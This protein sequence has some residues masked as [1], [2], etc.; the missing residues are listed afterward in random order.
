[1]IEEKVFHLQTENTSYIFRVSHLGKLENVYYGKSIK[2]VKD[3]RP[4]FENLAN[5]YPNSIIYNTKDENITLD[6]LSLEYSSIGKGDLRESACEI[7]SDI[8]GFVADFVYQ[9]Y[10]SYTG[11]KPLAGLPSSYDEY[12]ACESLEID[13]YDPVLEVTLTL[14][15]HAFYKSNI[16]TRYVELKNGEKTNLVIKRLMSMQFDFGAA[17][18]TMVTF[19]GSWAREM[20]RHDK[21]L[22]QGI[23]VND[24]K[25]GTSSNRHNPFVI[26]K[27]D[28]CTEDTGKCYGVNLVYSGNHSE[29]VEVNQYEKIR[30]LSGINP[31]CFAF[32]LKKGESFVTP[33]AVLSFSNNGLN[34]LSQNMHL[35][36]NEHIVPKAFKYKPRPVLINNWEATYF[37]F[38]ESKLLN[39]AKDAADLGVELF[40]LDDGWFGKR[41]DD[42]SSLG[43][44]AVN[45]K[46]LPNGLDGLAKKIND[47]GMD[48]GL[49]IEPEMI[50]EK[51]ELYKAHPEWVVKVPGRACS[52]ARNQFV[53]DLTH[54]NV[55]EYLIKTLSK[56]L[57]SAPITYV[58]WDMN[59]NFSD[60]YSTHLDAASQGEFYHRYV[61]GLYFIMD[62][63]T[64]AF[65]HVLFEGCSAGGN[66]FDLGILCYMPQIW[67]S[68]NT[69]AHER[70]KI[71]T[72]TSYAYPLSTMGAHV[73]AC[74]NHQTLRNTQLETRFNVAAAGVLGYELNVN[75]LDPNDKEVIKKQIA[76]YKKHRELLQFGIFYRVKNIYQ[77]N[78]VIWMIVDKS[79]SKA[80]MVFYQDRQI[81]NPSLDVLYTAGLDDN[82]FYSLTN[83]DQKI[84]LHTLRDTEK[85]EHKAYGDLLNNA[86][87]RPKS[88]FNGGYNDNTRV[89]GDFGSRI[90]II[91]ET[92]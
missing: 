17:D 64:K 63:L 39:I 1:M 15:Y 70:V 36:I 88:Q 38:D 26:I 55:C 41:N 89:L 58:K 14:Y 22:S 2:K 53:L 65:P 74:P 47:L 86:G 32:N 71:Q 91:E 4:L 16:I 30:L 82:K 8:G 87:F 25:T 85:E 7:W 80:I 24:S 49:W 79:K 19:D 54:K 13:L 51:S 23:Y 18:Y 68:D 45:T 90:Y 5:A 76:F 34:G 48:F 12:G 69:D 6:N 11:K 72:G 31:Y 35:F 21:K 67:T 56:L 28:S 77:S 3:Y 62:S 37:D 92:V 33:E 59:R 52:A 42:T 20:Q 44:W 50:S 46:K 10:R 75:E 83:R 27:Q 66:R 57:K 43:D 29:I 61:L 78:H 81:P 60:M 9:D 40:V 73:S 84:F